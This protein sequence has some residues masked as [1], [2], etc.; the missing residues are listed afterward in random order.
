MHYHRP[1]L[2][3]TLFNE[4]SRM[5]FL[6]FYRCFMS[7]L[8]MILS[9]SGPLDLVS[10]S[11]NCPTDFLHLGHAC[12]LLDLGLSLL[13]SP[14]SFRHCFLFLKYPL[15]SFPSP[16][17]MLWAQPIVTSSEKPSPSGRPGSPS[18]PLNWNFTFV[19]LVAIIMSEKPSDLSSHWGQRF[20]GRGLPRAHSGP[21]VDV[22]GYSSE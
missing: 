17:L 5:Y 19:Q 11:D 13:P 7:F 6:F 14:G 21:S 16:W 1:S 9:S 18:T 10:A 8:L 3:Y 4:P 20:A 22:P 15:S 2:S 12:L